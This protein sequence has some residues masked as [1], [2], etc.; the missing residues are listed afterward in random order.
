M[1][2]KEVKNIVRFLKNTDIIEFELEGPNGRVRIKRGTPVSQSVPAVKHPPLSKQ[3]KV[4][5]KPEV[6][7]D[8]LKTI[9]SPMVGTFYRTPS[10]D[11][12]PFVEIGSIVEKGQVLCIIE[13]MKLMN[14]I[15][16]EYNSK[17]ISILVENG[18]PVEYG[19]PLFVVE[20]T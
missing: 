1:D 11:V 8:R 18:Q 6:K 9:V 10:P 13:A 5:L 20:T 7:E 4:E 12:Q 16:S 2:L 19:E 15:E 17:I 14:E 3:E